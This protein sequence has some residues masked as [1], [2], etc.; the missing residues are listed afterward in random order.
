MGAQNNN[1]FNR[2]PFPNSNTTP[3]SNTP[4]NN[5]TGNSNNTANNNSAAIVTVRLCRYTISCC[6]IKVPPILLICS[7]IIPTQGSAGKLQA[8]PPTIIQPIPTP[9]IIVAP[10]ILTIPTIFLIRHPIIQ[11]I[12][13]QSIPMPTITLT[14]QPIA[15]IITTTFPP[16]IIIL[17]SP[18][19][20]ATTKARICLTQ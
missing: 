8:T 11:P 17:T 12:T 19:T 4:A 6:R 14:I 13:I 1:I 7:P 9:P 10:I 15:I 3:T 18:P 2:T 5:N 16:T 20:A